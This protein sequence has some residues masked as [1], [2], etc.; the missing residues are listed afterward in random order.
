MEAE[1]EIMV[2]VNPRTNARARPS[3]RG[4]FAEHDRAEASR[5]EMLSYLNDIS[6]PKN[7]YRLLGPFALIGGS[8]ARGRR[9]IVASQQSRWQGLPKIAVDYRAEK[10][11]Q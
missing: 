1:P 5:L 2:A 7:A 4:E 9:L 11:S 8:V 6:S 3:R 10:P